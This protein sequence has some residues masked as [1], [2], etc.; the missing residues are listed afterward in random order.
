MAPIRLSVNVVPTINKVNL[1]GNP[2]ID[3]PVKT[4]LV[5]LPVP[6]PQGPASGLNAVQLSVV[7]NGQTEFNIVSFPT[8]SFLYVNG[9]EHYF[10]I[11]YDF[12]TSGANKHLRWLNN[13]YQLSTTDYLIFKYT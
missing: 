10:G 4:V 12:V 7:A 3:N 9:V 13:G 11:D 6:G 5:S 8:Q 2:S 1:V